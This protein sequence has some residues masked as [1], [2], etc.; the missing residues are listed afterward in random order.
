L[1]QRKTPACFTDSVL[2]FVTKRVGG[3]SGHIDQDT[4][5]TSRNVQ[6]RL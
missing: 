6:F 4:K 2:R 3:K 1:F 5:L